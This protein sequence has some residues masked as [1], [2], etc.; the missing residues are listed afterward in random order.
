MRR[1]PVLIVLIASAAL[2]AP[3]I[4]FDAGGF[5]LQQH[6]HQLLRQ[7]IAPNND[8]RPQRGG[9]TNST[10]AS[11][12]F[13]RGQPRVQ[14]EWP[15]GSQSL[16]EAGSLSNWSG[17]RPNCTVAKTMSWTTRRFLRTWTA[18]VV[19]GVLGL[20]A[21]AEN[22]ESSVARFSHQAMLDSTPVDE[23]DRMATELQLQILQH[24]LTPADA[25]AFSTLAEAVDSAPKEHIAALLRVMTIILSI[26]QRH[27]QGGLL[28]H[29][30][31]Q[32][33]R[34]VALTLLGE[35]QPNLRGS[36]LRLM[37]QTISEEVIDA[38]LVALSDPDASV[39]MEAATLLGE[40][41]GSSYHDT[42]VTGAR[43]L[44]SHGDS[45]IRRSATLVLQLLRPDN[46]R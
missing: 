37:R 10:P 18:A 31:G 42:I 13:R 32:V 3:V 35:S 16:A 2:T 21:Q 43:E 9:L 11:R 36:A 46:V 5:A 24:G 30:D 44:V 34:D 7:Q 28:R 23:I 19:W 6:Q 39:R 29:G 26:D 25:L 12:R 1:R 4:A 33:A 20:S 8:V 40:Q 17:R 15:A 45:G 38:A 27:P 14:R 22:T 41:K